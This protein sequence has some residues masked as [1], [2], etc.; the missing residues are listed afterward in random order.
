MEVVPLVVPI[1][2]L[3]R[4]ESTS[5]MLGLAI[6]ISEVLDISLS[7]ARAQYFGGSGTSS[8]VEQRA[9][10]RYRLWEDLQE[11]ERFEENRRRD[12]EAEVSVRGS[13]VAQSLI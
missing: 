7:G 2:T 1:G 9:E 6:V 13:V 5:E 10:E 3:T 12:Q 11:Q 8:E 4:S